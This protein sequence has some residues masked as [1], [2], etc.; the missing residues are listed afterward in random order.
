MKK[1]I[2]ID[3]D[4][5]KAFIHHS[6]HLDWNLIPKELLSMTIPLRTGKEIKLV[7]L[8][9]QAKERVDS[10]ANYIRMALEIK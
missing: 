5:A 7:N 3:R 8:I 10:L 6:N 9:N 4:V 2:I 1:Y